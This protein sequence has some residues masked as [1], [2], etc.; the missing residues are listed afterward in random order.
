MAGTAEV[1]PQM[2]LP[3]LMI[4]QG[5]RTAAGRQRAGNSTSVLRGPLD[6][7][8]LHVSVRPIF[9][10]GSDIPAAAWGGCGCCCRGCV[11]C[12]HGGV[13]RGGD[14]FRACSGGCRPV[15]RVLLPCA[16]ADLG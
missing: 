13:V 11:L 10:F 2:P 6:W 12:L 15:R 14:G 16:G 1:L 9:T 4:Y 8:G 5:P 7:G 3:C